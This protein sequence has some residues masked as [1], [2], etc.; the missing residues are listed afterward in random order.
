MI[1]LKRIKKSYN[2]VNIFHELSLT[3]GHGELIGII[4]PSGMGK[5]TLSRVITGVESV[6]EG[7]VIGI[8][9]T[10]FSMV[11]QEDRLCENLSAIENIL[12]VCE[13]KWNVQIKEALCEILLEDSLQKPVS[14]LSGGMRRRVAIAKAMLANSDVIIM[15]EP[16]RG[17]DEKIQQ[18]VIE[19]IHKYRNNRALCL[20]VHQEEELK[21]FADIRIFDISNYQC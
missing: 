6:E 4:G 11:F 13:R 3:I 21:G 14:C 12:L 20:F 15:D 18:T 7:E 10:L 1:E 19:F 2:G 5:T 9:D 16:W 17:L 8:K